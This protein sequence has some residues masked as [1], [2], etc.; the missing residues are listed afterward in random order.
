MDG[1]ARSGGGVEATGAHCAHLRK[2]KRLIL[3]PNEWNIK[4][5]GLQSEQHLLILQA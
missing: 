4:S 5:K 1:P 2:S 3:G